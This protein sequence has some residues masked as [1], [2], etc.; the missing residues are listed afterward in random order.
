M[1][2]STLKLNAKE[3]E[4]QPNNSYTTKNMYWFV[5]RETVLEYFIFSEARG[6]T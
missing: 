6:H 3:K 1:N 2:P 5:P 4:G